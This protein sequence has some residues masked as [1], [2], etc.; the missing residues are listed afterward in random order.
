[1]TLREGVYSLLSTDE[2]LEAEGITA[3]DIWNIEAVDN[4]ERQKPFIVTAWADDRVTFGGRGSRELLVWAHDDS[5]DY[6][7][8]DR[9]LERVRIL[10]VGIVHEQGIS[11]VAFT[12]GSPDLYDDGFRTIT[13]NYGFRVNGL[14]EGSVT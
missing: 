13:R 2:L 8:I 5:A 11:Q 6:S 9:I 1:M 7:R 14:G 12:G 10:L 3:D 4:P